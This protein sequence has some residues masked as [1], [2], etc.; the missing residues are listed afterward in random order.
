MIK[1]EVIADSRCED[2]RLTTFVVTMPR[3]ILAE[4]NT[5]R[6]LSKNSASSRAIPFEKMLK[7]V[8]ENP[9]IPI[10]FQKEHSGM[11]GTEYFTHEEAEAAQLALHWGFLA[12]EATVKASAFSAKGVTKQLCNRM[13]E[14]FMW[15]TV[16]ISGT[17][18][19]NFFA[20]RCPKYTLF[21]ENMPME[22]R[23]RRDLIAYVKQVE[24]PEFKNS[25]DNLT[26]LEWLQTNKGKAE[27]HMMA[28]AEAMWDAYNESQPKTLQGGEWHIP[29]AEKIEKLYGKDTL[30]TF[31]SVGDKFVPQA[32]KISAIMCARVSYT[33]VGTELS[34][35]TVEKYCKK[36]DELTSAVPLHASPF[37]HV[38]RAMTEKENMQYFHYDPQS[39]DDYSER[40]IDPPLRNYGWC[41]NFR[42]F[43]QYRKMLPN[44]NVTA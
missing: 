33:V 24:A 41:G 44:E 6:M 30:E 38:A 22:F 19:E 43:V 3:I 13:L 34:E 5:H 4:L 29:Y 35:W 18:W 42:G 15:H 17:E 11:Q 16:I 31:S 25:Y 36:C 7:A 28:L 23:S 32:V 9:F 10:A 14:P 39:F 20:L 12:D 2:A 21:S 26:E 1:A 37:E 40:Q 27:I 8:R